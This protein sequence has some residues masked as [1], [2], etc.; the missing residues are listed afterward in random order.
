MGLEQRTGGSEE[1]TRGRRGDGTRK[2]RPDVQEPNRSC[3]DGG[4][5]S[6]SK[7][8][9]RPAHGYYVVGETEVEDDSWRWLS[10]T[11]P[12]SSQTRTF[13]FYPTVLDR[14]GPAPALLP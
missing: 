14:Q 8:N 3:G 10:A 9:A 13:F 12:H 5:M 1:E 11:K 7:E 4:M 6:S 2:R